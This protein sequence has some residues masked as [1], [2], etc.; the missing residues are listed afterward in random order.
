MQLVD[1]KLFGIKKRRVKREQRVKEH[2]YLN[3]YP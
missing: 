2:T 3:S 1:T